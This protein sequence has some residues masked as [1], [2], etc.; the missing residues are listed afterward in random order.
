MHCKEL[1]FKLIIRIEETNI[2][3]KGAYTSKVLETK[4]MQL[5]WMK[6]ETGFNVG[7]ISIVRKVFLPE[8][9]LGLKQL[10]KLI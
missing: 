10:L 2:F 6:A 4:K 8:K 5:L 9:L 1:I 7:L 3:R